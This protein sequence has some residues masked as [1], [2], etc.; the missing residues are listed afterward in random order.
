MAIGKGNRPKRIKTVFMVVNPTGEPVPVA[1]DT[2]NI[3]LPVINAPIASP[4]Q[5][6]KRRRDDDDDD[7]VF[8]FDF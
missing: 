6:P 5:A 1:R 8:D 4:Q 2:K 7:D 3:Y